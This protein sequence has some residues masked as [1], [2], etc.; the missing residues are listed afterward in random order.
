MGA[1]MA[2]LTILQ[3]KA[4]AAPLPPLSTWHSDI[5]RQNS[6]AHFPLLGFRVNTT[7]GGLCYSELLP[8]G[9]KITFSKL[10]FKAEPRS[11]VPDLHRPAARARCW[12][13]CTHPGVLVPSIF[14]RVKAD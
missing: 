12:V 3:I 9:H 6:S 5:C 1:G 7:L 11:S 10:K 4:K 14:H 8:Q 2:A 13:A